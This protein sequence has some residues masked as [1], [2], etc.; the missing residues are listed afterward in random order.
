MKKIIKRSKTLGIASANLIETLLKRGK[1]IFTL[2]EA[3]SVYGH[4]K[5]ETSDFLGDLLGR[6][7]LARIKSGLFII[8]QMGHEE[9]QL[10]N[11][12]LIAHYL[13]G[14]SNYYISH[15]SAMRL[16]GM[17]TH[18]LIDAIITVAK[19]RSTKKIHSVYYKFIYTQSK[20]FWGLSEH[21][22][23]KQEKIWVSDLE[24]TI[25][26][27]LNRPSL[28]GGIKE[29]I[30]GIWS[31]QNQIDWKKLLAY[32]EK[33]HSKAAVKRLGYVLE[34]LNLGLN[35]IPGLKKIISSKKDY[36][37]LDPNSHKSGRYLSRWYVQ[38]NIN[39]DEIKASVWGWYL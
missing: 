28:C 36:I 2:D 30:R 32:A 9:T 10:S 17:T 37:R 26:D 5:K 34:I 22:V 35:Y 14:G 15:Y 7:I 1:V 21:W 23:T 27:C 12:P 29:V 33:Y 16:H 11:W 6:G 31:K 24:K 39:I 19:R 18:P 20:N 38:L 8:L 3:S 25:L 13:V 4:G